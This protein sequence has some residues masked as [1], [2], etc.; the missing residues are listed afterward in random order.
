MTDT[1]IY[2]RASIPVDQQLALRTAA[3]RLADEFAG[4][5]GTETIERFLHSSYDQFAAAAR[6]RTSCHCS[7]NASPGSA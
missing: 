2:L 4:I 6:S 3:V 5:Y 7:P 1:S